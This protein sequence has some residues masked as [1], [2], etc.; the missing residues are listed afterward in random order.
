MSSALRLLLIS[1]FTPSRCETCNTTSIQS[2]ISS[3]NVLHIIYLEGYLKE[4]LENIKA[5][6]ENIQKFLHKINLLCNIYYILL[7]IQCG[8]DYIILTGC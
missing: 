4:A 1:K 3:Q 5:A 2:T 6:T 8:I 7:T